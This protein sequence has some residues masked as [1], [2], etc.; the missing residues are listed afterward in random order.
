[1]WA[2]AVARPLGRRRRVL[3]A[4]PLGIAL[5]GAVLLRAAILCH[6][7]GGIAWKGMLYPLRDLR[8]HRRMRFRL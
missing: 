8:A 6:A 4:L 5:M 3:L 1:M 7:R 2:L